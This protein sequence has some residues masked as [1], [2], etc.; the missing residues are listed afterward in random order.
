MHDKRS[1][2]AA[3]H[4]EICPATAHR[5]LQAR[6][7]ECTQ[8]RVAGASGME[9]V[10]RLCCTYS[11]LA[12]DDNIPQSHVDLALDVWAETAARED[13][14]RSELRAAGRNPV[15]I[16]PTWFPIAE[17]CRATPEQARLATRSGSIAQLAEATLHWRRQNDTPLHRMRTHAYY[18]VGLQER[19]SDGSHP[20]SDVSLDVTR[21]AIADHVERH[22]GI[23]PCVRLVHF[24]AF[25]DGLY[26]G[27]WNYQLTRLQDALRAAQEAPCA[28]GPL[29][30][31]VHLEHSGPCH[32]AHIS[33]QQPG[34][35]AGITLRLSGRRGH[36][37]CS[38][39]AEIRRAVQEV[40]GIEVCEGPS[41][42]RAQRIARF[43]ALRGR[44]VDLSIRL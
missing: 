2:A 41:V 27:R 1:A 34:G 43:T 25:F 14:L 6:E 13:L 40:G 44:S 32:S 15:A 3:Q 18:L 39:M 37:P 7:R 9:R 10:R 19:N 5:L 8:Y 38:T 21:I 16:L 4:Y 42:A 36:E 31:T 35:E 26:Q 12:F 22:L 28:S 17:L 33:F 29:L 23:R 24:D 20:C 11:R 30:L